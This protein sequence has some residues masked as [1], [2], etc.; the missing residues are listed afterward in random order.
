MTETSAPVVVDEALL[1]VA[2]AAIKRASANKLWVLDHMDSLRRKYPGKYVAY[3]RGKM[4]AVADTTDGIR[5]KLRKMKVP[6]IS[7]V[8]I[9]FVPERPVIW[10][11]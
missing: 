8:A 5:R 7:V 1:R 9:E 6:D 11:L 4:L 2:G 3:D 10:L